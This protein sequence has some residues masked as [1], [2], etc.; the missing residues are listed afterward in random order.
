M[1]AEDA[2]ICGHTR[3]QHDRRGCDVVIRADGLGCPCRGFRL[4]TGA[5]RDEDDGLHGYSDPRDARD[6]RW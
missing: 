6:D 2:C 4:D 5:E 3:E 1:N